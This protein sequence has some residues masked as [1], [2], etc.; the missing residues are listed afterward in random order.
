MNTKLTRFLAAFLMLCLLAGSALAE[1]LVVPAGEGMG[2]PGMTVPG[3]GGTFRPADF[4]Y[5]VKEEYNF[6]YMGMTF[7]LPKQLEDDMDNAKVTMIPTEKWTDDND[8]I[9]YA[10]FTWSRMT[11]E[12][13]AAEVDK[14]GNGFDEWEKSLTRGFAIGMYEK[15]MES[16]LDE[17]TRCT[18]HQKLGETSDGAYEYYLSTN[19]TGDKEMAEIAKQVKITLSE[20]APFENMSAF[21][22]PVAKQEKGSNVGT[23]STTDILGNPQTQDLFKKNKLTFVNVLGTFCTACIA[24]MPA[25]E[26]LSKDLADKG[27]GFVG[28]VVDTLNAKGEPDPEYIE[29]AKM[30]A[31]KTGTTFPMLVPSPDANWLNG[32]LTGVQSFPYSFLVD[33][34]GNYV[35]EGI[36]GSRSYEDWKALI[37]THLENLKEK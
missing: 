16:K 35:G 33:Q 5:Q 15:G 14:M 3:M 28:I 13:S 24:E 37:E 11:P 34:D 2:V 32:K 17:L 27:V 20:R 1:Q 23:F 29:K 36:S 26:K 6:A 10:F 21:D 22:E 4:G 9:R 18:E 30:L 19:P 31:E 7:D 25:L 8:N 12:Q